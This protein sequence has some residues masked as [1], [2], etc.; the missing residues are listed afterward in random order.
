M[1][2]VLITQ[3]TQTA[4]ITDTVGTERYQVVKLDTGAAG[5]SVPFTGTLGAVTN[6]AGGTLTALT[7]GTISVGTFAMTTGTLAGGTLQAGTV[8]TIGMRHADEFATVVSTG[9][10]TLGTI[11]AAVSGSQ[12]FLTSLI[13]S[14]GSATNVEIASGGTSTPIIGTMFFNANGGAALMPIDPPVR[15]VAGSALVYKQS[16]AISPLTIT[17]TGYVD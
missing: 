14:A 17:A 11:K 7:K 4:I 1:S 3:G 16:A 2:N 12:I 13:V 15:T 6:L 8:L 10:N 9:T 5:A